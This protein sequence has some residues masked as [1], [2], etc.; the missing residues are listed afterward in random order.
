MPSKDVLESFGVGG[1]VTTLAGGYETSVLVDG[2]VLK[3]VMNLDVSCACQ[4][5]LARCGSPL[6]PKPLSTSNDEWSA[7]GWI[8]TEFVGEL[9]PAR[10]DPVLLIDVGLDLARSVAAAGLIDEQP[11]RARVN[12]WALAERFAFQEAEL[13]LS[14]ETQSV[15][16]ELWCHVDDD[17]AAATLIHADLAGNVFVG[18][19]GT[20]VV[21]DFT[22]A[23]RSTG[24]QSG[25]VIADTLLWGDG[26][27]AHVEL[28][29]GDESSLARGLLF[30]L[31]AAELA[32]G[33]DNAELRRCERAVSDLGW[34]R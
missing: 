1:K 23:F 4:D 34:R 29:A 27:T 15:A 19:T 10:N 16:D 33:P 9:A 25:V 21:L 14:S 13:P 28:L 6:V 24:F 3:Q 20:P 8:A 26:D 11:I 5:V 2:V 30:R 12:R 22:P 17:P 7:D 18:S 31:V 32:P